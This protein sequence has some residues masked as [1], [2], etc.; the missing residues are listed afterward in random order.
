MQLKKPQNFRSLKLTEMIQ[1][2]FPCFEDI[3]LCCVKGLLAVD[4]SVSDRDTSIRAG[5]AFQEHLYMV[6]VRQGQTAFQAAE[7]VRVWIVSL[8]FTESVMRVRSCRKFPRVNFYSVDIWY[9]S[10]F[11]IHL[12]EKGHQYKTV[13]RVP[14]PRSC[15]ICLALVYPAVCY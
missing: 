10:L 1:L 15:E 9:S 13:E 2:A 7:Q 4:C 14:A 8:L 11:N 3:C 12:G 6:V 5:Q